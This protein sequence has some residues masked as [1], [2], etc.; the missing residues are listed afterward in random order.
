MIN[1]IFDEEYYERMNK[2]IEK[3]GVKY[4]L[5]KS[6]KNENTYGNAIFCLTPHKEPFTI[7]K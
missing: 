7:K 6:F 4:R 5:S 3:Y 2:I 1:D